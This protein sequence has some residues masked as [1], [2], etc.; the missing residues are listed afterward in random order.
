MRL[1]FFQTA[2]LLMETTGRQV[3]IR[4]EEARLRLEKSEVNRL[5]AD[6]R[7]MSTLYGWLS[8]VSFAEGLE[9]TVDWIARNMAFFD[10][11]GYAV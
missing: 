4:C 8:Q 9:R 1:P 3:P 7:R 2:K 5:L 10:P 6:N 11:G